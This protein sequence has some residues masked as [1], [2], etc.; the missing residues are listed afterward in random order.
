MQASVIFRSLF[1]RRYTFGDEL[2]LGD[3]IE[4]T[5]E[6]AAARYFNKEYYEASLTYLVTPSD[7][8][9]LTA[10]Y[11]LPREYPE[12]LC[13]S[14]FLHPRSFLRPLITDL[15]SWTILYRGIVN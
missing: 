14:R 5:R 3:K 1:A 4:Q 13:R 6:E 9:K 15:I 7:Y 8:D 2:C 12:D 10:T 11:F